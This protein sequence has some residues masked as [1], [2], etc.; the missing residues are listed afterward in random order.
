[1]KSSFFGAYGFWHCGE[2]F[3]TIL[4]MWYMAFHAQLSASEIGFYQALQLV[5]F[6]AFTALG[7]SLTDRLGARVTFSASTGLFALTLGFYGLAEPAVGFSPWLFGGYCLLSGLLSAVSNPAIDTFIP[8]ATPRGPGENAL[9]AVTVHNVA[10]LSGNAATLLLP[11][12]QATGGFIVNGVLMAASALMLA[13]LP[14]PARPPRK[15]HAAHARHRIPAHFRAHPASFDIFLGSVMLGLLVIPGFYIFHPMV[16]RLKF[17]EQADLFGLTG[18]V[19]WVGAI[20]A[21]ALMVRLGARVSHPGRVA[22]LVWSA[23]AMAFVT[24]AIVTSFAGF[25]LIWLLLGGQSVGKAMIYGHFLRDAP[26]AD[27]GLL[28]GIDQT[29]LW[30]LATVGTIALGWLVDRVGL[31]LAILLNSGAILAFVAVLGLRGQLWR[32]GR[33]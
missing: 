2:G 4:M 24:L 6:L 17:P 30:G 21:S 3:Q 12:L 23:A 15:L 20:L 5:P 9:L 18:V 33:A 26:E 28:I 31:N 10:K 22:L 19:G 16:M 13:R 29:A 1:M 7:G 8:D 11:L 14:R 32:L 27:R 25:L